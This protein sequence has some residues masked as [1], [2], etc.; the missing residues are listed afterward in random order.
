MPN[1][2][3]SA[4]VVSDV[5]YSLQ[6][7]VMSGTNIADADRQRFVPAKAAAVS[8][9]RIGVVL[10]AT[11]GDN[12]L[13]GGGAAILRPHRSAAKMSFCCNSTCLEWTSGRTRP[14]F[15]PFQCFRSLRGWQLNRN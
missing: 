1:Y 9:E 2:R 11:P 7:I 6:S 14:A 3:N 15:L 13:L 5:S 12:L 10:V 4:M 8:R